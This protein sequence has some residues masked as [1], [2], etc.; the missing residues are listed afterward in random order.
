M[1]SGM[2]SCS[3]VNSR[4]S[5]INEPPPSGVGDVNVFADENGDEV[6]FVVER[7]VARGGELYMDYGRSYSRDSYNDSGD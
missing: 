7:P 5:R 6:T 3:V 2:R 1:R 4:L